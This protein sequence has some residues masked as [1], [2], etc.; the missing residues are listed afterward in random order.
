M[1][2]RT[3]LERLLSPDPIDPG[4]GKTGER[5]DVYVDF[6][7]DGGDPTER[8]AGLFAH[9]RDCPPCAQ[10]FEGLVAAAAS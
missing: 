1:T 4:C 8:F 3:A 7:L 2:D 5:L 9:L 6:V 10:D